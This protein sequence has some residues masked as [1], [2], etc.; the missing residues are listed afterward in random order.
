MKN[1][2]LLFLV[3]CFTVAFA[4]ES[5]LNFDEKI[6]KE[7]YEEALKMKC[8]DAKENIAEKCLDKN[9]QRFSS[10]CR[11]LHSERKKSKAH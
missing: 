11:S 1:V 6:E 2:I 9:N 5:H 4:Q 7:C 8:V 3:T 10:K